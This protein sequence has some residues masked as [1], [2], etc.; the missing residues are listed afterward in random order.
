M[1][2]VKCLSLSPFVFHIHVH[3]HFPV[4]GTRGELATFGSLGMVL[5]MGL[6]A[7]IR[8]KVICQEVPSPRVGT[9]LWGLSEMSALVRRSPRHSQEGW[10]CMCVQCEFTYKPFRGIVFQV[11]VWSN[12]TKL[13]SGPLK[14]DHFVLRTVQNPQ[15]FILQG[16]AIEKS[17]FFFYIFA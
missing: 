9:A 17:I 1:L 7:A 4:C 16:Y 8:S 3:V 13:A 2:C 10:V 6:E 12:A 11:F 5:I 14:I 15:I